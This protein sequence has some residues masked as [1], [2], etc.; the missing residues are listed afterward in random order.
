M[1]DKGKCTHPNC[2]ARRFLEYDHIKPLALGGKTNVLN[3]R[4]L[5]RAH[6]QRA[7][8][9]RFGFRMSRYLKDQ[10]TNAF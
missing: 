8:I 9:E 4:L 10:E 2:N 7:A 3:L 6:N 5:C 1:R